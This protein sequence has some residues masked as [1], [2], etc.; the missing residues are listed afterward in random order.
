M[1]LRRILTLSHALM[2]FVF[3]DLALGQLVPP[4][5]TSGNIDA[6]EVPNSLLQ[7]PSETG[8]Y[9]VYMNSQLEGSSIVPLPKN[10]L[11]QDQQTEGGDVFV[12]LIADE[13]SKYTTWS[14]ASPFDV[15]AKQLELWL[16]LDIEEMATEAPG[17][18]VHLSVDKENLQPFRISLTEKDITDAG[19]ELIQVLARWSLPDLP[20]KKG[21]EVSISFSGDR[22]QGL[23]LWGAG[24]SHVEFRTEPKEP[25]P[26]QA[27]YSV[28]QVK[29]DDSDIE[30][31][32]PRS[33]PATDAEAKS[34]LSTPRTW[35]DST[36]QHHVRARLKSVLVQLEK[37]NGDVVAIP[38]D[39]LSKE[40]KEY[41]RQN[42]K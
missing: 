22:T 33:M 17:F 37:E 7:V 21:D 3:P 29:I 27:A 4:D 5:A 1:Q 8:K 38:I 36:G 25:S 39:G 34:G 18:D 32:D 30:Q 28:Q 2:L 20:I 16:R 31:P 19:G 12:P 26:Y 10:A 23:K 11:E 9:R 42:L 24:L 35:T 15:A 13:P 41:V 6:T 14:G 40:D